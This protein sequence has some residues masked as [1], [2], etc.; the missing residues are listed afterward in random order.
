MAFAVYLYGLQ[1]GSEET[2][3]TQAFAVLV[4]AEL[5]RAFGARSDTKPVW[6]IPLLSN[7]NLAI[8]VSVSFGLQV[9]SHHDSTLGRFLK[10]EFIPLS[11]CFMLLA[12]GALPLLILEV[13]KVVR[14][15]RRARKSRTLP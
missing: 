7:L 5:L 4:F 9:W 1:T 14:S 11:D 13:V 15:A 2:A 10:T 12:A 8:V 6:R 3:R